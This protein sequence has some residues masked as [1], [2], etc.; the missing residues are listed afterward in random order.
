MANGTD[1]KTDDAPVVPFWKKFDIQGFLAAGI[2]IAC[3][4]LALIRMFHPTPADDKVL[5]MM[6]TVLFTTCLVTVYNYTFGSSK[7]SDAKQIPMN[8]VVESVAAANAASPPP[9]P[10]PSPPAPPAPNPAPA[11]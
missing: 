7:G 5:D 11:Q 10:T 2:L 1:A 6:L 3:V 9:A 8:K 4:A